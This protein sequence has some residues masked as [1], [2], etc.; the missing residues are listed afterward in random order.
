MKNEYNFVLALNDLDIQQ[1][2]KA[3]AISD[4][5]YCALYQFIEG[6]IVEQVSAQDVAQALD[7]VDNCNSSKLDRSKLSYASESPERVEGFVEIINRRLR[8]FHESSVAGDLEPE[9]FDF[10]DTICR[11]TL[12]IKQRANLD[13]SQPL[14][15]NLLSASDFGFHNA[16]QSDQ[17]TVFIDFEY[18][19]LD[20]AWKMFSDFYAQPEKPVP[21]NTAGMF[22]R[23]PLFEELSKHSNMTVN[24]FHLTLLKWCLIMLNEFLKDVQERRLFSWAL[25]SRSDCQQQLQRIQRH[26]LAKS[27]VYYNNI[28]QKLK[29][30]KLILEECKF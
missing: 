3:I 12:F 14:T 30:L 13:W 19:G 8:K 4:R 9:L 25:T 16:I 10:L 27:K 28:L 23:H 21:M 18:A 24:L 26:Q 15:R 29:E 17:I 2:P 22:L 6:R 7:F 20:S 5:I 11:D 1:V